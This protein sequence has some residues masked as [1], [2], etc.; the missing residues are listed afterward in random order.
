MLI[1]N[2][3]YWGDCLEIMSGLP[4]GSVDMICVDPPFGTTQS[5]WDKVIPYADFWKQHNRVIKDN[6]AIVVN[7]ALPF[8]ADLIVANRRY[9]KY[10]YIWAKNKSTNYLNAKK[11]PL[12]QHEL[13][14]VFYKNPPTYNPQKTQRHKP[15]NSYTK[16]PNRDHVYGALKYETVGGGQTD[17]YPTSI[18]K[19]SVV[20]NDSPEREHVNQK[21]LEMLRWL[22][23]TYTN[24]GEIVLDSCL[25]S[26]STAVAAL[27]EGRHFVGIELDYEMCIK[28]ITRIK[29]DC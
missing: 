2:I 1:T 9:F 13:L 22:I 12:R 23:R 26:G 24:P 28:A 25:G 8:A 7:A 5:K 14:L 10:E 6:G 3:V 17:R 15:V 20:N 16:K 21:P 19:W 4:A 29:R 27:Q 18:Q 11:M